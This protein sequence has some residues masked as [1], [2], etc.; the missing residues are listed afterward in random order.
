MQRAGYGAGDRAA[1]VLDSQGGR[2]M[3]VVTG[4]RGLVDHRSPAVRQQLHRRGI[5]KSAGAGNRRIT[6]GVSAD[7]ADD[8]R[9]RRGRPSRSD[10]TNAVTRCADGNAHDHIVGDCVI[11]RRVAADAGTDAA[12]VVRRCPARAEV[13]AVDGIRMLSCMSPAM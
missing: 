7:R 10:N 1:D 8:G 9:A 2:I 11:Y 6:N 12:V 4:D 5:I 3:N 13:T